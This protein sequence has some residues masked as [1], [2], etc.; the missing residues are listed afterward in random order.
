MLLRS[1]HMIVAVLALDQVMGFELM[2]PGQ[3]FGMANLAAAELGDGR[4][5][6]PA[7]PPQFEVRVC[8]QHRSISTTADWGLTEIRTP[9]GMDAL[10]DADL[11]IVP[12]THRFLERPDPQVISA[13]RAAA[14]NGCGSQRCAL[15]PSRWPL[16]A[17]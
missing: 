8:G 5:G 9:H 4:N 11:V 14:D 10:A 16:P 13:L 2:I 3:V 1:S 15:G 12:G 17:C 7:D 6:D